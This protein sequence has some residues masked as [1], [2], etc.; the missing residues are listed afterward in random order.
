M[1]G[2]ARRGRRTAGSAR[3]GAGR[4]SVRPT[5]IAACAAALLAAGCGLVDETDEVLGS[6]RSVEAPDT[7][8]VGSVFEVTVTTTGPDGCWGRARTETGVDGL[9]ATITPY[10]NHHRGGYCT[11][12]PVEIVHTAALVFEESGTGRIRV[13]GRDGS[14]AEVRVTV[15][16]LPPL[17][18]E[19]EAGAGALPSGRAF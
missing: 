19:A 11:M 14:G 1:T 8:G 13:Y 18:R 3:G 12:M 5:V 7:V 6:V 2:E 10:D 9:V 16:P 17:L 15:E 4:T